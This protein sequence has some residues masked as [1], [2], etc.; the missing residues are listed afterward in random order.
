MDK[1][2]SYDETNNL[3]KQNFMASD[4][5]KKYSAHLAEADKQEK[6]KQNE[7][8]AIQGLKRDYQTLAQ[9][10]NVLRDQAL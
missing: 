8:Q 5:Y 4:F 10:Y 6:T 1:K 3:W 9:K 2:L 7:I